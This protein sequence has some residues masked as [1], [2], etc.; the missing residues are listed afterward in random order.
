MSHRKEYQQYVSV[1]NVSCRERDLPGASDSCGKRTLP[2]MLCTTP[3]T[4]CPSSVFSSQHARQ[5]YAPT[6]VFCNGS[7]S[8]LRTLTSEATAVA[9]DQQ[10]IRHP[11]AIV[12][13]D[14]EFRSAALWS[15]SLF[16]RSRVAPVEAESLI[17]LKTLI[18]IADE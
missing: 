16:Q 2:A 9:F 8:N 10:R 7:F 1:I 11:L 15:A 3:V 4:G 12:F 14:G 18:L 6:K 13:R 17:Q 5:N